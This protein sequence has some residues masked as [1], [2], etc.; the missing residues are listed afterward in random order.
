MTSYE[1][2]HHLFEAAIIGAGPV[3]IELAIAFKRLDIDYIHFEQG[4][5]GQM[6]SN[7]PAQTRFF[8]S[9]ERISIAGIP[10]HTVAQEKCTREEYLAYLRMIVGYFQL[11]IQTYEPVAAIERDPAA[12]EFLIR[13]HSY[14]RERICKA[15]NVILATGGTA[16]PRRLNIAGEELPHVSSKMEDPH[17]YFQQDLLVI[18]GKNSAVETALRCCNAG[19]KV[20]M[21]VRGPK[22]RSEEV[23]YWLLPEI[24]GRIQRKEIVCYFDAEVLQIFPHHA[25]IGAH[26]G[27]FRIQADFVVKA[28]GFEAEMGLFRQLG[29]SLSADGEVPEFD[30]RTMETEVKGV[31]ALGTATGGTQKKYRVF[32]ENC[33]EHVAK[34]ARTL[35]GRLRKSEKILSL[36]PKAGP[37]LLTG[38]VAEE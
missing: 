38:R 20:T 32:I 1:K 13:T 30:A 4:Q 8:S 17:R 35:A 29:V 24:E 25:E 23:K 28:I 34:I 16:R 27:I 12:G 2:E 19:A 18:G 31:F 7:F 37:D 6:I 21:A 5:A 9:S 22:F 26:G 14:G 33:H 11:K 36:L 15:Q 10:I 3:G